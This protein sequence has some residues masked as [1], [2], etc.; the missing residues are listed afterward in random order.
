MRKPYVSPRSPLMSPLRQGVSAKEVNLREDR[1]AD[2]ARRH[3]V[4]EY[5]T[6]WT[7]TC[8][9]ALRQA[10]TVEER[11]G[12]VR[13]MPVP[14]YADGGAV[15]ESVVQVAF[16][17]VAWK[18]A[19][20]N[21]S[22]WSGWRGPNHKV[23]EF[24]RAPAAFASAVTRSFTRAY[25]AERSPEGL[26]CVN[27]YGGLLQIRIARDEAALI[28]SDLNLA[29]LREIGKIE[30][31]C[32]QPNCT[33]GLATTA[34]PST[35]NF[36]EQPGRHRRPPRS[37]P[38]ASILAGDVGAHDLGVPG[39]ISMVE[40]QLTNSMSSR[41]TGILWCKDVDDGRHGERVYEVIFSGARR[42]DAVWLTRAQVLEGAARR[43]AA[44][45]VGSPG[46]LNE[47]DEVTAWM[48]EADASRWEPSTFNRFLMRLRGPQGAAE[49]LARA[50][51]A[52]GLNRDAAQARVGDG[53]A[54]ALTSAGWTRNARSSE[55][56]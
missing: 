19:K 3:E 10:H 23:A 12:A 13:A 26:T 1:I 34:T 18:A 25:E 5:S 16:D 7:I 24:E 55:E 2:E 43:D 33:R 44:T 48:D 28:A 52:A 46:E 54:R 45:T 50:S 47:I 15:P 30:M 21:C 39:A 27:A 4:E 42:R 29:L 51:R 8:V 38:E 56:R 53:A 22:L 36:V 11:M 40:E 14:T 32:K 9:G 31:V 20:D 37:Q 49:L 35:R 17:G 41:V 6:A